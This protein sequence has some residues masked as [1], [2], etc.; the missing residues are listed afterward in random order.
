ML[1]KKS[2]NSV[3]RWVGILAVVCGMLP[4]TAWGQSA[5]PDSQV[6][7]ITFFPVPYASYN[8]LFIGKKLDIGIG[9]NYTVTLGHQDCKG[10]SVNTLLSNNDD[11]LPSI[12]TQNTPI[13]LRN[14]SGANNRLNL[15]LKAPIQVN[16]ISL[17]QK[18]NAGS[19]QVSD[20]TLT[21]S[22]LQLGDPY[23][24]WAGVD[25]LQTANITTMEVYAYS[26]TSDRATKLNFP[27]CSNAVWESHK[28]DETNY[29]VLVCK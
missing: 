28:F 12:W 23:K 13:F 25:E 20:A 2:K 6:Q 18:Y 22:Y 8:N 24:K 15:N 11:Y 19:L 29:Y 7:M 17:G 5:T 27:S 21:F 3:V 4:G 10:Q 1:Q 9:A 16:T 14:I 26:D